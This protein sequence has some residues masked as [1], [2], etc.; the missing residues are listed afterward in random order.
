MLQA[1]QLAMDTD[2]IDIVRMDEG[3]K[4]MIRDLEQTEREAQERKTRK[5]TRAD[6]VGYGHGEDV[7]SEIEEEE[8][9]VMQKQIRD[10]R[11][12]KVQE[13]VRRGQSPAPLRKRDA[14]AA[15]H[16]QGGGHTVKASGD[17]Y[18][19]AKGKGDMLKSGT[20]EP[21]AYIKLNPEMLNPKKKNQAVASFAGVVSHGKKVDKRTMKRKEGMMAGL[22]AKQ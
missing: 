5:R 19:S 14:K 4:I 9:R 11:S 12:R 22:S 6:V 18:K 1:E 20:H 15:S 7:D 3:G 8:I 2:K 21:Y 16:G 17:Q 10:S 13:P